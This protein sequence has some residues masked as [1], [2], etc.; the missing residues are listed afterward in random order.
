M[1]PPSWPSGP[2]CGGTPPRSTRA[3]AAEAA[4]P[5]PLRR[6][7]ICSN[8]S[9]TAAERDLWTRNEVPAS[10]ASAIFD[11]LADRWQLSPKPQ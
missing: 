7:A 9:L 8:E 3:K 10:V 4:P 1:S 11:C 6:G 5:R 2:V